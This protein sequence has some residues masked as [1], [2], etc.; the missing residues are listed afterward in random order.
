MLFPN[1]KEYRYFALSFIIVLIDESMNFALSPG[2]VNLFVEL[3]VIAIWGLLLFYLRSMSSL[4]NSR[5]GDEV[6]MWYRLIL[7][8]VYADFMAGV[9]KAGGGS[10]FWGNMLSATSIMASITAAARLLTSFFGR[11]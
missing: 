10:V 4:A 9:A 8:S 5:G 1:Q 7:L 2:A 11:K 6:D 3:I